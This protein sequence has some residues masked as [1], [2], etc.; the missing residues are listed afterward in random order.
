MLFLI[1]L[2]AVGAVLYVV[3]DKGYLDK[4]TDLIVEQLSGEVQETD[5]KT[6]TG[7]AAT[8]DAEEKEEASREEVRTEDESK[9]LPED[10]AF[11]ALTR[12]EAGRQVYMGEALPRGTYVYRYKVGKCVWVSR[13]RD[14][15]SGLGRNGLDVEDRS[16][17]NPIEGN[18][19]PRSLWRAEPFA[20]YRNEK[21]LG[22]W[23]P[24]SRALR[25]SRPD[26][27]PTI[28][29]YRNR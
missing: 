4:L 1:M 19:V 14:A 26:E 18:Y 7:A 22:I 3:W 8:P 5:H 23:D 17:G 25:E 28:L 12:V 9:S 6:D 21:L 13:G 29:L 2:A 20:C 15:M 24:T 27:A 11:L 16:E 10:F